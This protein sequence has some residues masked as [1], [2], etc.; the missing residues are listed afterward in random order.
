MGMGTWGMQVE[1]ISADNL[2]KICPE[3]F[4]QLD[5][6]LS[7]INGSWGELAQGLA[8]GYLGDFLEEA[9]EVD[10]NEI[11]NL[12]VALTVDFEKKTGLELSATHYDEDNGDRYDEAHDHDGMIFTLGGV[13]QMTPAAEKMKDMIEHSNFTMWG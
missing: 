11:N 12:W 5:K 6:E 9:E 10:L 13:Y 4:N 2:K 7:R 1:S 8:E 3:Y